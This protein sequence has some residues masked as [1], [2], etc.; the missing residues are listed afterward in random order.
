MIYQDFVTIIMF[1]VMELKIDLKFRFIAHLINFYINIIPIVLKRY[2]AYIY[3]DTNAIE[4][5]WRMIIKII[6]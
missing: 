1:N 4:I 5:S 2:F 6:L 3:Y